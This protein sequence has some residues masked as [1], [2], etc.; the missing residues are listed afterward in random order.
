M[1]LSAIQA[2]EPAIDEGCISVGLRLGLIG[3]RHSFPF[4]PYF[5]LYAR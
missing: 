3:T 1:P 5:N 4:G 2:V